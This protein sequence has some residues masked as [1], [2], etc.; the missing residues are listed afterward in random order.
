MKKLNFAD[1]TLRE[2]ACACGGALSFREK[3]EIAKLLDRLNIPVIETAPI[4]NVRVDSLLIK[5]I[6]SSAPSSVIS[7]PVALS[8]Q[9]VDIAWE[10]VSAAKRARLRVCAPTSPVQMEYMIGKKPAA[11]LAIIEETVKAAA[12]KCGE[13]EFVA[14]DA[15]RA[16]PEFLCETV[17]AAIKCGAGVVTL[18]DNAGTMLPEE[19]EEFINDLRK[20]VPEVQNITLGMECTDNL[21]MATACAASAIKCG[22]SEI[23]V[24]A[25]GEGV[26]SLSAAVR[27]LMARGADC[28]V[29]ASVRV[30]ELQR[31]ISQIR[32]ISEVR[33]S[34]T[35]AFSGGVQDYDGEAMLSI[36]DDAA[37]VQTAVLKLGYDLSEED[38]VKV[39]EGFKRIAV[40]KDIGL[41]ELD[42]IVASY[43][44]QVPPTYAVESYV[45]NSGNIITATAN[46]QLRRGDALMQ[47]VCVGDGPIDAA[48]LAIEQISG[49][50]FELD[51]FQIKAVT[52]GR[53]AMGEAVIRL[54]SGGKL[55]SG[56]GTSTD[57]IGASVRAYVSALNKI[58]YEEA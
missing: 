21:G 5:S 20:Y 40:K 16:D 45:I 27:F 2:G 9:G 36:H 11:I 42:A 30:T 13:V 50:H 43:A 33:H 14:Q 17:R 38:M 23:K 3:I 34:K 51:D 46:V 32:R 57:I 6:V 28:G 53:E 1:V 4:S 15:T 7:V 31:V 22:V 49:C 56:R 47:G 55:Y 12:S 19:L 10:A 29:E 39:F 26:L 24:A 25:C 8:V 18:C 35:S 37:A 58:V 52:E 44:L 54:R 48:F 41:K